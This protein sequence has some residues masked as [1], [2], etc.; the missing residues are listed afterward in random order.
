M[1]EAAAH[2]Y[3]LRAPL[4]AS[5]SAFLEARASSVFQT[6][7]WL[8]HLSRRGLP[9]ADQPFLLSAEAAGRPVGV[10]PLLRTTLRRGGISIPVLGSLTNYYALDFSPMCEPGAD[11]LLANALR[12][13]RAAIL[14]FDS[15]ED[16]AARRMEAILV[17]AGYRPQRFASFVNW[18]EEPGSAG[19][20][21][22][23]ARR[24]SQLRN[25]WRR[26]SKKLEA[27]TGARIVLHGWPSLASRSAGVAGG[28]PI[29]R[30]PTL[31]GL[32]EAW[33]DVYSRSWKPPEPY[34]EFV[35]GLIRLAARRKWLR[36]GVLYLGERPIAAQLWLHH[37][38]RSIVYKLAYDEAFSE[39]SP[40]LILSVEMFRNTITVDRASIIDYGSGD[41][42]YKK[43]WM[44]TRRVRVGLE[45]FSL[46]HPLGLVAGM[47][48]KLREHSRA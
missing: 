16:D 12:H 1:K 15:M 8:A 3:D 40:G 9:E 2:R 47:A 26:R 23:F 36:L 31:H 18:V 30:D 25:S 43:D 10:L 6:G 35:P 22:W 42:A 20:E 21:E 39:L 29:A 13:E 38:G 41:D 32:I 19:F 46:T 17:A 37:R 14:R 45:A 34:P 44:S 28:I 4:P 5:V 27:K 11:M 7:D 48:T 33:S 24:P